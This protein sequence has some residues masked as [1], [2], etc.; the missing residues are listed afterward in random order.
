MEVE[1]T[2][3]EGVVFCQLGPI[4][5]SITH[6]QEVCSRGSCPPG[7]YG[8]KADRYSCGLLPYVK[9]KEKLYNKIILQKKKKKYPSY[10]GFSI[11]SHYILPNESSSGVR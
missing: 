8:N 5:K 1:S 11:K 2:T 9:K 4:H 6:G 10:T 3:E 7:L